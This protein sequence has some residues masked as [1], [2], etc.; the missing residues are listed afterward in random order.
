MEIT[1]FAFFSNEI[2]IS[3]GSLGFLAMFTKSIFKTLLGHISLL[4]VSIMKSNN[5]NQLNTQ[6]WRLVMREVLKTVFDRL[7]GIFT[8][9]GLAKLLEHLKDYKITYSIVVAISSILGLV[10]EADKV[11]LKI[12]SVATLLSSMIS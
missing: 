6:A 12:V 9:D 10:V 7:K 5:V 11:A 4:V 3:Q 2:P 1:S 8:K